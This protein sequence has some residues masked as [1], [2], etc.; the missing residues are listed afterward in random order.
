M[1]PILNVYDYLINAVGMTHTQVRECIACYFDGGLSVWGRSLNRR[2]AQMLNNDDSQMIIRHLKT[3]ANNRAYPRG[4]GLAILD[5]AWPK[6]SEHPIIEWVYIV[7]V[8]R[9]IQVGMNDADRQ[10]LRQ[11]IERVLR[12]EQQTAHEIWE[13]RMVATALVIRKL[14][15]FT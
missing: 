12:Y 14:W 13:D 5:A 8:L 11:P 7:P 4:K 3:I 2:K 15:S 6:D 10:R 9:F 1:S